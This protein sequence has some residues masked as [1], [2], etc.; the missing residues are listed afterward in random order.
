MKKS[1]K[2]ELKVVLF[3]F[4]DEG[5]TNLLYRGLKDINNFKTIPTLPWNIETIN[6]NGIDMT[7]WDIGGRVYRV[8]GDRERFLPIGDV[9]IFFIDSSQSVNPNDNCSDFKYNF[10]EF[11]KSLELIKDKPLLIAITKI[12]KRKVSTL[13]II[14]AYQLNDLFKRKQKVG[15]IECSSFTSQGIKEIKFWLSNI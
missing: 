9:I 11:Q 13:D 6:I 4:Q 3:G 10:E 5:K 14:H 7:F 8:K 2:K 12:D 15:I 1:N